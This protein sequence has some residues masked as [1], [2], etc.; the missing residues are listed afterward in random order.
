F[1]GN[2]QV[3]LSFSPQ[4]EFGPMGPRWK[5]LWGNEVIRNSSPQSSSSDMFG[6]AVHHLVRARICI[7]RGRAWQAEY[8]ISAA[9]DQALSLACR[10]HGLPTSYGRG[11]DQLPSGLLESFKETL[12][13]VVDRTH[14]LDALRRTVGL[15]LANSN[16]VR[17]LASRLESQL[18]ELEIDKI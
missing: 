1:P 3:D 7:E 17:A 8:W 11:Y 2:L 13:S 6:L 4:A 12:V 14:L 9:R 18:H 16:D 5:L 15:L 10:S